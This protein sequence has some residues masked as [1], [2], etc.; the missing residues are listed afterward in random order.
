M[1]RIYSGNIRD[2]GKGMFECCCRSLCRAKTLTDCDDQL[3]LGF[4]TNNEL[5]PIWS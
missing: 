3:I 5:R 1:I 2:S 4:L